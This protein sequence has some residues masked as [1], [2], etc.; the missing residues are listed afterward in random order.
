MTAKEAPKADQHVGECGTAQGIGRAGG[1]VLRSGTVQDRDR[2]DQEKLDHPLR[3]LCC[4]ED[5]HHS[6]RILC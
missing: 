2:E 3:I 4:S 1:V 6:C 5:S